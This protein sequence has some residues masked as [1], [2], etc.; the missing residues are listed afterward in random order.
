MKRNR[1]SFGR[2]R[3]QRGLD[4]FDTPPI[5]LPPLFRHEPLLAGVTAV[6]EPFCGK[7][8]LVITMRAHGLVVHASDIQDRGCPSSTVLGFLKMTKRPPD[9]DVLLSNPPYAETMRIIEHAWAL[10][11]RVV[12]LLLPLSFLC[13]FE[14]FERLHKSGRLRRVHVLAERLQDMHD[15]NFTG[16]KASQSQVHA[17][18]VLDRDYYG[19][20]TISPVSINAPDVCM[21][22]QSAGIC[23]QCHK[24]YQPRRSSSRFC[25]GACRIRAYRQR[26][27]VTVSVTSP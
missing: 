1:P 10:G 3:K 4:Q 23:E 8:N 17:W 27:S 7:G 2:T 22:W 16:K 12:V 24:T 25:S 20:A 19:F 15:A 26:L 5:A 21:P 13:T 14:R 18:F 6:A 9:C 11:F